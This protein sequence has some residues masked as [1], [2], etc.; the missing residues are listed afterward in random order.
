MPD[1]HSAAFGRRDQDTAGIVSYNRCVLTLYQQVQMAIDLVE[2]ELSSAITAPEAAAHAGMSLRSFHRYFPA[3]TGFRFSEYCRKR[4][5]SVGAEALRSPGRSILTVAIESGYDS[6]EAF[7][8]AFAREFG[9]TPSEYRQNTPRLRTVGAINL[10][11][12]VTMDVHRKTL[13]TMTAVRFDGYKPDPEQAAALRM[14]EWIDRHPDR[15][16]THRVLGYNIDEHGSL[17]HEPDN[18]GYRL[19]LTLPDGAEP[20]G[21]EAD[22]LETIPGGV[23]LVTGIEGSFDE[24]P[25]GSWITEG[26]SRLGAQVEPRGFELHPSHRWFEESLE[27]AED[28]HVRF[29]LYLEVVETGSPIRYG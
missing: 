25:T 22:L 3:L 27:P 8:R 2:A 4:R 18:V 29:D 5:L 15:V 23:F 6:N 13:P 17:A 20:L 9:T 19:L 14:Q 11:G 12:E 24:D 21:I 7:T 26:W 16:G 1:D 10:V 28:G